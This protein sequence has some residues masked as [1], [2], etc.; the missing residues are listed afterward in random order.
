MKTR[1]AIPQQATPSID[2]GGEDMSP[3]MKI[4]TGV[5]AVLAITGC[6]SG[7]NVS[8]G[9]GPNYGA[10]AIGALAGGVLGAQVGAGVGRNVAI[11]AGAGTGAVLGSR[12]DCN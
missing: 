4:L 12:V 8:S 1:A 9:C 6:A 10:A 3:V 2:T 7:P 5:I 11:A